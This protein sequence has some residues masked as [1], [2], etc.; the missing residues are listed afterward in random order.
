[1]CEEKGMQAI[2]TME[3][4]KRDELKARWK[5]RHRCIQENVEAFGK[6]ERT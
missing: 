1:M 4:K 6:K 2:N 5:L 3:Y